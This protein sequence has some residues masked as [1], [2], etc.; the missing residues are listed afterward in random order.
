MWYSRKNR[1]VLNGKVYVEDCGSGS[2]YHRFNGDG[3]QFV[4]EDHNGD[5]E[6]GAATLL[7]YKVV[8]PTKD[9][10]PM[11]WKNVFNAFTVKVTDYYGNDGS[12]QLVFNDGDQ[13]DQPGL[14]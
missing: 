10:Q 12:F 11:K 4:D 13:F 14:Q 6:D 2:Y 1:I 8:I 3:N 7:L 9:T 5:D